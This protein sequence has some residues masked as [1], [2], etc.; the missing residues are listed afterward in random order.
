MSVSYG[1]EDCN[2]Q[3]RYRKYGI[4]EGCIPAICVDCGAFGCQCDVV[5]V[6]KETFFKKHAESDDNIN[7]ENPYAV[8]KLEKFVLAVE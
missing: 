6:P 7:W 5:N 8:K 2:H 4:E 3:W 1:R